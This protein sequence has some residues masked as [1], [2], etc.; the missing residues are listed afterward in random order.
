MTDKDREIKVAEYKYPDADTAFDAACDALK[1][2][3]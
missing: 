1:A 3:M 2:L